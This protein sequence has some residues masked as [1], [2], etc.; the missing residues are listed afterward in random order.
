MQNFAE[1]EL[2]N[3]S[4]DDVNA[5]AVKIFRIREKKLKA[6]ANKGHDQH[7]VAMSDISNV[8]TEN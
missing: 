3:A 5:R 8:K 1:S 4:V 6:R 2:P 7:V